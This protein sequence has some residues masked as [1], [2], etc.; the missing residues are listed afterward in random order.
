MTDPTVPPSHSPLLQ[1]AGLRHAGRT[2]EAPFEVALADGERLAI[3]RL[4][5]VLPGKR[6]VGEAA[7]RG[8]RVLAKLFVARNNEKYWA[9]EC[10]GLDALHAAGIDTPAVVARG[11][12]DG[13]GHAVLTEFLSDAH[14]LADR[15]RTASERPAGDAQALGVLRPAFELL[16]RMHAAGLIQTDLHLG[17]FLAHRGQVYVI[18]GDGVRH[19]DERSALANLA[20]LLA[21]LPAAWD[22]HRDALLAAYCAG[23]KRPHPSAREL[24]RAVGQARERRLSHFLDKTLRDCS[25]FAV[26]RS[27]DLFSAVVRADRECLSAIIEEPDRAIA[28]GILLKDGGSSTVARIDVDGR[29]LV[30][31]R[32]N[33]KDFRHALS[34]CWRPSRAWHSWLAG[35]RLE[36]FGIPTP[37]PLGLLEERF[38]PLRRRAFLVTEYCPGENL[39]RHLSPDHAP[40]KREAEAIRDFFQ[41]LVRLRISHGDLKATNL[42]WHEDKLVVIDLDAMIRH[43]S[44]KTFARAWRRDRAR[45]LRNWPESSAL[46][47]WLEANLPEAR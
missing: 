10:R 35:H 27:T 29:P 40:G 30:I 43:D 28:R 9:R 20:L 15:W 22:A 18:D 37:A 41:A 16:G 38:G 8:Q 14:S 31:K 1:A 47:R 32:Y 44:D 7:W 4:L 11:R 39:L 33:L 3:T 5:R 36:F 42:L 12:L 34:R 19:A 2:P 17:N 13:G 45:F 24:A 21:Q 46:H 26:S 6:I 25:Q 23:Q